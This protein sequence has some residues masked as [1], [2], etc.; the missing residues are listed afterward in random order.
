M[1]ENI[2]QKE[3]LSNQYNER[4]VNKQWETPNPIKV[5]RVPK[6]PQVQMIQS[7][8]FRVLIDYIHES[9]H[10]EKARLKRWHPTMTTVRRER[11]E[12]VTG[13]D[14]GTHLP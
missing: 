1:V 11:E 7:S 12:L 4:A 2:L 13:R 6:A 10:L 5:N 8:L 3:I 9:Y 14:T